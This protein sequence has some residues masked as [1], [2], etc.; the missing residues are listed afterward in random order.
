LLS[1]ATLSLS[2]LLWIGLFY[3]DRTGEYQWHDGTSPTFLTWDIGDPA[4]EE[5]S[6]VGILSVYGQ[7]K[8]VQIKIVLPDSAKNYTHLLFE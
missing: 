5:G 7:S 4:M 3:T 8:E 6:C 2:E 1:Q